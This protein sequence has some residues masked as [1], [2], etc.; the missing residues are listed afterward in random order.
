[1]AHARISTQMNNFNFKTS[2]WEPL[3]EPYTFELDATRA[4][5]VQSLDIGLS[6]NETLNMNLTHTFLD[7]LMAVSGAWSAIQVM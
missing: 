6:S 1:M 3:I 5:N 7:T 4:T 2:H